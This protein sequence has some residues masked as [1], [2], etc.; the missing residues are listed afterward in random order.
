MSAVKTQRPLTLNGKEWY[1]LNK[2]AI[3][4]SFFVMAGAIDV[5]IG[6]GAAGVF[7]NSRFLWH[8]IVQVRWRMLAY[9]FYGPRSHESRDL[10]FARVLSD[11]SVTAPA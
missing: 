2:C 6:Q 4:E 9:Y 1:I 3:I 11:F 10:V 5:A 8:Q 7:S